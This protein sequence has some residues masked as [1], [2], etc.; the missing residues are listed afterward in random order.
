MGCRLTIATEVKGPNI[1]AGGRS[2]LPHTTHEQPGLTRAVSDLLRL[3]VSRAT[4]V[5]DARVASVRADVDKSGRVS[6]HRVDARQL[7]TVVRRHAL[8]V[9]VALALAGAVAARPVQLAVVLGVE[10]DLRGVS[11]SLLHG[12]GFAYN[13]DGSATVVLDDL[14]RGV[15]GTTADNPA[16]CSGLVVFLAEISFS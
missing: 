11:L 1:R 6:V 2:T 7:A 8:D 3:A 14:V 15:V 13:V 4:V 10:V 16:L 9:D 12:L 5:E